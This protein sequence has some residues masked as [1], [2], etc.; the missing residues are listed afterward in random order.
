M[1]LTTVSDNVDELYKTP[2]DSPSTRTDLCD[3]TLHC[4]TGPCCCGC[5]CCCHRKFP[6][7]KQLQRSVCRRCCINTELG[8]YLLIGLISATNGFFTTNWGTYGLAILFTRVFSGLITLSWIVKFVSLLISTGRTLGRN[9]KVQLDTNTDGDIDS[10]CCHQA[11]TS[12]S[13]FLQEYDYHGSKPKR[14]K[15]ESTVSTMF[16]T[17][18]LTVFLTIP[19]LMSVHIMTAVQYLSQDLP[20]QTTSTWGTD[21]LGSSKTSKYQVS[22]PVTADVKLFD[23]LFGDLAPCSLLLGSIT[24]FPD[25]TIVF[26]NITKEPPTS[27]APRYPF[28]HQYVKYNSQLKMDIYYP[29]EKKE[30]DKFPIFLYYHGGGWRYGDRKRDVPLCTVQFLLD[31]GIAFV[32]VDYRV[33]QH[34]FN[35]SHILEDTFDAIHFLKA[36]G[37]KYQLDSQK[38]VVSGNSAGGHLAMMSG[39]V[40]NSSVVAGVV[41][42][43]GVEPGYNPTNRTHGSQFHGKQK[44]MQYYFSPTNHI[45]R[46]SPPTLLIHGADDTAVNVKA[47]TYVSD[48]LQKYNVTHQMISV[49]GQNHACDIE[50]FGPCYTTQAYTL[51]YF[52]HNVFDLDK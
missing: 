6:C 44:F 25:K 32:S 47:S 23:W 4:L 18:S 28:D 3:A 5:C 36:N 14:T 8:S 2:T 11:A 17:M 27:S 12:I 51:Q 9:Q 21:Y 39:Y 19:F 48:R 30:T 34:G 35:G 43:W 45:N 15:Y 38:I 40:L 49:P 41:T 1:E 42:L 46:M 24:Y 10:T 33:L 29:Q 7:P 31:R 50:P 16:S 37:H 52:L 13:I 26:K 22:G 20:L